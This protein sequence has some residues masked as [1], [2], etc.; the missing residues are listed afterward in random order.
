M[1]FKKEKVIC[2]QLT[3][4]RPAYLFAESVENLTKT[5]FGLSVLI[6]AITSYVVGFSFLSDLVDVLVESL[7]EGLLCF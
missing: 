3:K 2:D 1:S 7:L 5:L 6:S 4:I